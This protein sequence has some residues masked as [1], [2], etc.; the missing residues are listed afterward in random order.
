MHL[1]WLLGMALLVGTSS[2]LA[3]QIGAEEKYRSKLTTLEVT[4]LD[5]KKGMLAARTA[6]GFPG[7]SGFIEGTGKLS[8]NV[9]NFSPK[10]ESRDQETC[11]VTVVFNKKHSVATIRASGCTAYSGAACGWE[12]DAM[13]RVK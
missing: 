6:V 8:G 3:Q 2:T 13:K 5:A 4:P 12:G 7:C 11:Q 9:L 10:K 1:K